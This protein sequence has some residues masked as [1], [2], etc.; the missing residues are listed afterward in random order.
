L[1]DPPRGGGRP[2]ILSARR[3][4]RASVL[5]DRLAL[6]LRTRSVARVFSGAPPAAFRQPIL[7]EAIGKGLRVLGNDAA[8]NLVSK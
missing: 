3:P 8:S 5:P 1:S 6:V 2:V 7:T 4:V